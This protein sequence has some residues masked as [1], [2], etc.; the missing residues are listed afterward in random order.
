MKNNMTTKLAIRMEPEEKDLL[1]YYAR[2][3][4]LSPSALIRNQVK[5]LLKEMEEKLTDK[6]YLQLTSLDAYKGP[7]YS[8]EDIEKLF[9]IKQQ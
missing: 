7:T 8:Q 1:F 5:V 6:Y 3:L 4:G 9:E 2:R